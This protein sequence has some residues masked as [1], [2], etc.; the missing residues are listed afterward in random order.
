MK[1]I[2]S[3]LFIISLGL[4]FNITKVKAADFSTSI[5]GV[6]SINANSEFT[7]TIN[8][9]GT[10][11]IGLTL[12]L[13]YDTSK[14][15]LITGSG[16]DP[17]NLT[18]GSSFVID[19]IGGKSGTFGVATLTFQAKSTFTPGTATTISVN[20]ITG[21]D[22]N[23]DLIGSGSSKT[24]TVNV[25]KNSNNNLSNLTLNNKTITNFNQNTT[26]Y[27]EVVENNVTS[28]NINATASDSKATVAGTGN[29]TL[30]IYDNIYYVVVT[31][32]NGSKKTY[33]INIIRKD[34]NNRTKAL[35]SNNNLTT[36]NI[37]DYEIAFNPDVLEYEI[38]VKSNVNN[39]EINATA[40]DTAKIKINNI[41]KLKAGTNIIDII[42]TA[43][44]K[45]TKTYKINVI[46]EKKLI[47]DKNNSQDSND[48]IAW[49]IVFIESL[50]IIAM[51]L[52][53]FFRIKK[54]NL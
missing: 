2:I 53:Y 36:L 29:K 52:Y 40:D 48:N 44:N 25:P 49:I 15:T 8:V 21:T 30:N 54:K 43:E 3:I 6:S 14:L 5:S 31:A 26:A 17:Y 1:K 38:N 45:D 10:N 16:V 18:I 23:N 32:E 37:K 12:N 50:T 9:T 42:V 13:N 51:L 47:C 46:K 11:I 39:I 41:K 28:I 20:N 27:T 19:S 7:V 33:S 34:E 22:N 4:F 35:S 24:I